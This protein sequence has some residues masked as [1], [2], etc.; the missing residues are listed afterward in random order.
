MT[1]KVT[2]E[3][4]ETEQK[5]RNILESLQEMSIEEMEGLNKELYREV[6]VL[7]HM[8]SLLFELISIRKDDVVEEK[9]AAE[10][11]NRDQ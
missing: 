11:A 8:R 10:E 9:Q 4:K 5:A 7:E 3:R 6:K 1:I 2:S